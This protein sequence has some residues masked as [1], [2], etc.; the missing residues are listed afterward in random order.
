VRNR[1][2]LT[3]FG[4]SPLLN[5]PRLRSRL[6]RIRVPTLILRAA[7][8]RVI[9]ERYTRSYADAIPGSK[10]EMVPNAGHYVHDEQPEALVRR[11]ALFA[12]QSR[13]NGA[14][15]ELQAK[16]SLS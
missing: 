13:D 3:W 14:P 9:T 10:I 12:A 1:E 7:D 15:E 16:V 2:S 4:W 11:I 5:N 6:H 8:D